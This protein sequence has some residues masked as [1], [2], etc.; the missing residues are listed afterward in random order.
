M[1]SNYWYYT[2]SA[3]PQ[4][5]AAMIALAA[6]FVVFKL[7]VISKKITEGRIDLRR[8]ILLVTSLLD[9]NVDSTEIHEIEPLNHKDFLKLYEKG[10]INLMPKDDFL[11][12][13]EDIY[14]KYKKEMERII[15]KEWHSYYP[16]DPDRIFGY[17][18]MKKEFFKRLLLDRIRI[19]F[20]LKVSLT[21]VT[22]TI[23]ISLIVLPNYDYFCGSQCVVGFIVFLSALSIL[24]T[25]VS[26][27]IITKIGE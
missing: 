26:V 7:D 10:L 20:L 6:M 1:D 8:F 14:N 2:L 3:I 12:L 22:L 27:W 4:T 19:L 15:E 17:L 24:I 5:L 18:S 9:K 21:M 25:S 13:K 16:A 23:I 11:G